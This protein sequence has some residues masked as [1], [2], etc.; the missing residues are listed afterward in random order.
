MIISIKSGSDASYVLE[1][2]ANLCDAR[3]ELCAQEHQDA[4][5]ASVKAALAGARSEAMHIANTLRELSE[6]LGATG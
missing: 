4:T 3:A 5:L 2:V 1:Q 6:N